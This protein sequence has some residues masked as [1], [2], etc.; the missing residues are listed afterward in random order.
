MNVNHYSCCCFWCE[1]RGLAE[2]NKTKGS[3]VKSPR[4]KKSLVLHSRR[5]VTCYVELLAGTNVLP[6]VAVCG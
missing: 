2:M 6:S 4:S 3:K 1:K 5:S